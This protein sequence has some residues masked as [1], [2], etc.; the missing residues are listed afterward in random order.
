MSSTL[1]NLAPATGCA[2][3]I[4]GDQAGAHAVDADGAVLRRQYD[5]L[6]RRLVAL[7]AAE[8]PDLVA[9]D[10]AINKL[11]QLQSDI[12][13]TRGLIGNNPIED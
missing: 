3:T 10:H 7:H 2:T 6:R 11:A 1:R 8:E 4:S 9:I 13:A 12:K 5:E